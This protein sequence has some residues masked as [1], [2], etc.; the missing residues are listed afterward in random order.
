MVGFR[1]ADDERRR[2]DR[3]D[4][5]SFGGYTAFISGALR[6]FINK[7]LPL[8]R[9]EPSVS[10]RIS[11]KRGMSIILLGTWAFDN[12]PVLATELWSALSR[13]SDRLLWNRSLSFGKQCER[14]RELQEEVW[15][16]SDSTV[17]LSR[18]PAV[19][20]AFSGD[21]TDV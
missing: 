19:S 13:D 8:S 4:G 16:E 18:G 6:L 1:V 5:D 11:E 21:T 2:K 17:S 14:L 10:N 3:N 12:K 15:D 20:E 9:R 7:A